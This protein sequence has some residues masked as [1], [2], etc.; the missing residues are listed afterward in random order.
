MH[1]ITLIPDWHVGHE[2]KDKYTQLEQK[3]VKY[4]PCSVCGKMMRPVPT[5]ILKELYVHNEDVELEHVQH[6]CSAC[7]QLE[8]ARRSAGLPASEEKQ[9]VE[10]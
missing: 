8:D 2:Q 9:A 1:A 4:E 10:A 5:H 3:T 7:R 6:L